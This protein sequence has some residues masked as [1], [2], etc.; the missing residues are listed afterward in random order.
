MEVADRYARE[1]VEGFESN[2]LAEGNAFED[3]PDGG[4]P[5]L[6]SV[7]CPSEARVMQKER[8]ERDESKRDT[9]III[10]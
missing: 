1:A 4:N 3:R 6:I 2:V 10:N 8:S 9:V 7:N 5:K